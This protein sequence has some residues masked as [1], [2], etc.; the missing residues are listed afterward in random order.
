MS[1][2]ELVLGLPTGR[3]MGSSSWRGVLHGDV[4]PYLDLIAAEGMYRPRGDV[5]DDPGWKQIIPYVLLR[6]RGSIFLMRRTRAGADARLH[7]R[8][9]VGIGGHVNPDDGGVQGGLLREWAEELNADWQPDLRLVG[10]LN[11]D[12]DPVG[13]VHLGVV[14][15]ADAGGREVGVR[16]SDK[17]SGAFVAPVAVLRVYERL[18]T[19]SSLLY[20]YVTGRSGGT[21]VEAHRRTR[22]G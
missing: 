8:W 20:D 19:W 22:V 3:I 12:S 6:D 2:D 16:E 5:E 10:L 9:S 4:A 1:A 11:D 18:E 21:R 7:E 17:L 14:F 15:S 13:R